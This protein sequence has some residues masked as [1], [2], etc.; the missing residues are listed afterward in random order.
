G[1][2]VA[3]SWSARGWLTWLTGVTNPTKETTP[4]RASYEETLV[5]G[6]RRAVTLEDLRTVDYALQVLNRCITTAVKGSIYPIANDSFKLL[7]FQIGSVLPSQGDE[8][9]LT[10]FLQRLVI[11]LQADTYKEQAGVH[12]MRRDLIMRSTAITLHT[13]TQDMVGKFYL[14]QA[15]AL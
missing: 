12:E 7:V 14:D 4:H 3:Q 1:W 2:G 11:L 13:F 15:S 9:E 8:L 5:H 10:C 6:L